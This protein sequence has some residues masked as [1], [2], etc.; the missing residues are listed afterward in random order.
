MFSPQQDLHLKVSKWTGTHPF[1][2][3]LKWTKTCM[4]VSCFHGWRYVFLV[5]CMHRVI[6]PFSWPWSVTT[7]KISENHLGSIKKISGVLI[8]VRIFAN[9]GHLSDKGSSF[10]LQKRASRCQRQKKEKEKKRKYEQLFSFLCHSL[11]SFLTFFSP[12]TVQLQ[13]KHFLFFPFWLSCFC[14]LSW[15]MMMMFCL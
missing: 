11:A 13:H 8:T 4:L 1:R 2:G 6:A 15:D 12:K 3:F 10:P 9:R 14:L 5:F 7:W